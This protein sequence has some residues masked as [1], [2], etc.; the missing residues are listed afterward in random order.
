MAECLKTSTV[1]LVLHPGGHAGTGPP[2]SGLD[3]RS[4]PEQLAPLPSGYRDHE[5]VSRWLDPA[6][7]RAGHPCAPTARLGPAGHRGSPFLTSGNVAGEVRNT[8]ASLVTAVMSSGSP[9][10]LQPRMMSR[11][12]STRAVLPIDGRDPD[13]HGRG[14]RRR[15]ASHRPFDG[16]PWPEAGNVGEGRSLARSR[17]RAPSCCAPRRPAIPP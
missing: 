5:V 14:R 12:S 1:D 3:C 10:G 15:R 9:D 7:R 11:T 6:T 2:G 8:G 16:H 17:A 13:D 4:S